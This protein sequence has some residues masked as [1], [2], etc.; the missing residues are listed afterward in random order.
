MPFSLG[1][2]AA[3]GGGSAASDYELIS[4][5]L[6]TGTQNA[7]SLTSIPGTY[8]HLQLRYTLRGDSGFTGGQNVDITFNSDTGSNYAWH[9]MSSSGSTPT[10]S[11]ASSQ[12]VIRQNQ[13]YPLGGN[14]SGIYCAAVMD[15]L[16]YAS[17]TKTKT[18][19][20]MQGVLVPSNSWIKLDSGLWNSTDALTSINI[21]GTNNNFVAGSRV[22]L[23]GVKG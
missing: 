2:W 1:F 5:T 21:S 7:I 22:S 16:D 8:K 17:T 3:A 19:R 6:L 18:V 14:A 9:Q 4:T 20:R 15:I 23:Y 10:T 11:G 12:S 13:G